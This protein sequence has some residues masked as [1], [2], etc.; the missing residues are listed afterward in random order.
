MKKKLKLKRWVKTVITATVILIGI[1]IYS[2]VKALGGDA[3]NSQI[4][5]VLCITGW[6]YL[7]FGQIVILSGLWE[8]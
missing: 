2:G 5:S 8:D 1:V 4:A 3:N 6:T 7:V